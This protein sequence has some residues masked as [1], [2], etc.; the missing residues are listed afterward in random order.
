M[1]ACR[2]QYPG[3]SD[4]A[5]RSYSSPSEVAFPVDRAGRLLRYVFEAFSKITHIATYM[6]T[7]ALK[8]LFAPKAP[9][10]SLPLPLLR[11]LPGETNQFPG[12]ATYLRV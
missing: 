1:H 2:R 3:R 10:A 6:L 9:A 12:E 7:E 5:V 11:L 4:E 8:Q